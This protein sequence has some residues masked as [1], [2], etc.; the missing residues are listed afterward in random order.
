MLLNTAISDILELHTSR[1]YFHK[2]KVNKKKCVCS[3]LIDKFR[4]NPSSMAMGT[5]WKATVKVAN[6]ARILVMGFLLVTNVLAQDQNVD[7]EKIPY[8][9]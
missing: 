7:D 5:K 3:D 6:C 8:S 1:L 9:Q 2:K 4:E